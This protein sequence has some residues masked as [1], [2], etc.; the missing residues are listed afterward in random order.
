MSN[1]LSDPQASAY[2]KREASGN[3]QVL[4]NAAR[5][6]NDTVERFP[7]PA[8]QIVEC[9]MINVLCVELAG[10]LERIKELEAK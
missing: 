7:M 9:A 2:D 4:R 6:I 5:T 1:S 3:P 10:A 8:T